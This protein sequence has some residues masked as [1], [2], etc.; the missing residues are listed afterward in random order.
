MTDS[1]S[2]QLYDLRGRPLTALDY[3]IE[4]ALGNIEGHS[5]ERKFGF[6]TDL[7]TTT[8]ETIASWGG[9]LSILT[10]AETI[11]FAS[12]S[13]EDGAAGETGAL[14][15]RVSGVDGNF[16]DVEETIVLNGT[17]AKVTTNSYRM[18]NRLRVITAGSART[19]VGAI[20]GTAS[21]A[22]SIQCQVPTG[23]STS[24]QVFFMV[25]NN[26]IFVIEEID[27]DAVRLAGGQQPVVTVRVYQHDFGPA[28][29]PGTTAIVF[30]DTFDTAVTPGT[31]GKSL[32]GIPFMAGTVLEFTAISDLAATSVDGHMILDHVEV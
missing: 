17:G 19:N 1:I 26:H 31:E 11:S 6:N 28:D 9:R 20:T 23:Y 4:S 22:G 14:T 2:T 5:P 18:V 12:T 27:I 32:I 13:D 3:K 29:L 24:Q 25:P 16:N 15:L 21:S 8:F 7:N 10:T 30:E